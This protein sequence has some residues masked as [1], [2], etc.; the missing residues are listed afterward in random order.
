M[1]NGHNQDQ[2]EPEASAPSPLSFIAL[3]RALLAD[4]FITH[5]YRLVIGFLALISVDFLQLSIPLLV[6][7]AIDSLAAQEATMSRLITV[8]GTILAIAMTVVKPGK[9]PTVMPSIK[10][11]P[12]IKKVSTLSNSV[13]PSNKFSTIR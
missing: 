5:R 10:P 3:V 9:A 2:V 8:A 6:K 7:S 13:R 12:V 11:K 4:Q 1:N